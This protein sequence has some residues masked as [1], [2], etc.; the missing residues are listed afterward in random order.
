MQESSHK[1]EKEIEYIKK[2]IT[3]LGHSNATVEKVLYEKGQLFCPDATDHDFGYDPDEFHSKVGYDSF[4]SLYKAHGGKALLYIDND[5]KCTA[6]PAAGSLIFVRF[7]DNHRDCFTSK[8]PLTQADVA[9]II[10]VCGICHNWHLKVTEGKRRG[11]HNLN[12]IGI[13]NNAYDQEV[14]D[15]LVKRLEG[16]LHHS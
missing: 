1:K 10:C 4:I 13:A 3:I 8:K 6:I 7:P 16:W 15:T 9:E 2:N 14:N 5:G 12:W 11:L